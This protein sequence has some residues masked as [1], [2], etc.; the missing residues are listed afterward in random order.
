MNSTQ[1]LQRGNWLLDATDN[2]Y[3]IVQSLT[4]FLMVERFQNDIY[5]AEILRLHPI[6]I[7]TYRLSLAK[8]QPIDNYYEITVNG[9]HCVVVPLP[10]KVYAW[11]VNEE[12]KKEIVYI[13]ELQ[14]SYLIDTG[15]MLSINLFG[16][17]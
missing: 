10:D 1:D 5:T 11:W 7:T 3:C 16:S 14:N 12:F 2:N 9:F 8:F 17:R 6:P 13:H 4:P 15:V